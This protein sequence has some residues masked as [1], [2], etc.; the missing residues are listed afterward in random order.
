MGPDALVIAENES[1]AQNM[2]KGPD[3]LETAENKSGSA[4]HENGT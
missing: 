2:K 3:T 4:K 1:S